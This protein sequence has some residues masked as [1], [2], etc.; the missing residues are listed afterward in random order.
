MKFEPVLYKLSNG[1]PVILDPMDS[2]DVAMHVYLKG[3]ASLEKTEEYGI[4]H[5]LE[6]MV[7]NGTKSFRGKDSIPRAISNRGGIING[8]TF[9]LSTRYFGRALS[10]KFPVLQKVISEMVT[11]P[12]ISEKHI[13]VERDTVIQ[14]LNQRKKDT[15]DNLVRK[16][17]FPETY[18]ARNQIIG[19]LETLESFDH[20]IIESYRRQTYTADNVV[21]AIS[22]NFGDQEKIIKELDLYF[23]ILQTTSERQIPAIRPNNNIHYFNQ[24]TAIDSNQ[25]TFFFGAKHPFPEL[26][27]HSYEGCCLI[28]FKSILRLRLYNKLRLDNGLIYSLA[29]NNV[30]PANNRF[31]GFS[32]IFP[33]NR[34]SDVASHIAETLDELKHNEISKSELNKIRALV[35]RE[36]KDLL[37]LSEERCNLLTSYFANNGI[38]YDIKSN[39][40]VNKKLNPSDVMKYGQQWLSNPGSVI[41]SGTPIPSDF[42]F[43]QLIKN[44][45]ESARC[46]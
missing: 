2:D 20:T 45:I 7:F 35:E 8:E 6:H 22:G 32:S 1:I 44:T 43:K 25:T 4:T 13:P 34:V 30:G 37:R 9:H 40:S 28:F 15:F 27:E 14:E 18:Y 46:R 31:L 41:G 36:D 3:G 5:F 11:C 10:N 24:K 17:L 42:D 33:T 12:I 16:S 38:V 19:S 39:Y 26:N 29:H 23:S 21:I